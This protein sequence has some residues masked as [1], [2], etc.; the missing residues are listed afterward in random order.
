MAVP[1]VKDRIIGCL[2]GTAMG[3]AIG[4][5]YEGLSRRRGVRLFGPPDRHRFIVGHGM[6]SDDTEHTCI[7]AQSLIASRGDPEAF[8]LQLAKRL[9]FWLLGCPAGIGLATLRSILRLW[10]G[11]SPHRSGVFSAGN[12][13]AMRSAI[14]GASVDNVREMKKL[15]HVATGITHTD[16]KAEYGA[17]AVALAARMARERGNVAPECF[18]ERLISVVGED[19]SEFIQ[20]VEVAVRSVDSGQT[21]EEFADSIGLSNGVT[22]YVYHSVPVTIH[23]WLRHPLDFRAAITAVVC[24][25]GDTDTTGAMVGGIVGASVGKAEY[26]QTG[27]PACGNG[28]GLCHGWN[29]WLGNWRTQCFRIHLSGQLRFSTQGCCCATRF[30]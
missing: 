21:T 11:V 30:S 2:L 3:D 29:A 6:V 9:R 26:R 5:P 22:G 10:A 28:P 19:A 8:Q 15:V 16:P 1:I 23:A 24:C 17:L 13:P 14:I 25:G 12:G 18:L 27:W 4:L 20:L 7:V